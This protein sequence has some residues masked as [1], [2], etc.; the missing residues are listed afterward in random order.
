MPSDNFVK[1]EMLKVE[2]SQFAF[3]IL[4]NL[5][6]YIIITLWL[7]TIRTSWPLWIVWILIVVQFLLYFLIF[8]NSWERSK[9]FGI[10]PYI[11]IVIFICLALLGR[12]NDWEIIIIPLMI[13]A[14]LITSGINKKVSKD[15]LF[16][17]S[18]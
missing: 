4:S 18:K 15:G 5:A 17:D 13:I 2:R 9:D 12:I 8:R 14:M 6:G 7:N 16:K 1:E 11:G 10:N 3:S